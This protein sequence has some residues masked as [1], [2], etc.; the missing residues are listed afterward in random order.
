MHRENQDCQIYSS[1]SY[2]KRTYH[3]S[4]QECPK[5]IKTVRFILAPAITRELTFCQAKNTLRASRLSDSFQ[6]QPLWENLPTVKPRMPQE[7]QDCQI[8]SSSAYHERTYQ[9]SSKECPKSIK[10]VRFMPALATTRELTSCQAM[11]APRAS[12]LSDSFQLKLQWANLPTVKPRMPQ[13]HQDHQIHS[14]S[15]HHK[16][17]YQ[18]WMPQEHQDCEIHSSSSQ[19]E[20]TYFL[21]SKECPKSIKDVKFITAP[22]TI[23]ELTFCQGKNATR[24]SLLSDSFQLQSPWENWRSSIK[25]RM[26]QEHQG[27]QIHSSFSHNEITYKLWSQECPQE[28]QDC[29]IDSGYSHHDNTYM[30]SRKECPKSIKI[31]H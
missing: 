20:R 26:P 5:S 12:R 25:A 8:Q 29:Q 17:I 15:S 3:L 9:L 4:S 13:K 22:P 23:R 31:L 2:H 19:R 30:L 28:H 1:S 18:L 6:L 11:N 16:R 10:T 21:S 14:S 7:H 27:C 24:A